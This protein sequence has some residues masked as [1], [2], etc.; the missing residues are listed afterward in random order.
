MKYAWQ[1]QFPDHF[2]LFKIVLVSHMSI[3]HS[4]QVDS[5]QAT[6]YGK[7]TPGTER[8]IVVGVHSYDTLCW[9]CSCSAV[10]QPP[11]MRVLMSLQQYLMPA[12][13]TGETHTVAV[14]HTARCRVYVTQQQCTSENAIPLDAVC[15]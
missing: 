15:Q 1:K 11:T 14:L 2:S 9:S 7:I 5:S 12:V 4:G 13:A 6:M 8:N 3:G 10:S